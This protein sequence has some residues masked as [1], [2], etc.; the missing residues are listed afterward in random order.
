[1]KTPNTEMSSNMKRKAEK[2]WCFGIRGMFAYLGSEER[3]TKPCVNPDHSTQ[4]SASP[5]RADRRPSTLGR[6]LAST[7][8]SGLTNRVRVPC[9]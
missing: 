8:A 7:R 1:M 3:S 4:T 2:V 6:T 5:T 9:G